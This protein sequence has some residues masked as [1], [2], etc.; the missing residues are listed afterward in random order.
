[1][2]HESDDRNRHNVLACVYGCEGS[3]SGVP[4][5]SLFFLDLKKLPQAL[6]TPPGLCGVGGLP[7]PPRP[8]VNMGVWAHLIV[9]LASNCAHPFVVRKKEFKDPEST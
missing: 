1:M 2:R 5:P 3:G 4:D 7:F 9:H 8:E 6:Q